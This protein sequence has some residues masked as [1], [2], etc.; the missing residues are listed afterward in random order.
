MLEALYL[1]PSLC[2]TEDLLIIIVFFKGNASLGFSPFQSP[3]AWFDSLKDS[4]ITKKWC[5]L[6]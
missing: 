6:K 1:Y 5:G 2:W 4:P 3:F